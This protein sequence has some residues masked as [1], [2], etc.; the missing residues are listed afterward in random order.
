MKTELSEFEEKLLAEMQVGLVKAF[1]ERISS[2]YDSN[3]LAKALTSA[4]AKFAPRIQEQVENAISAA[5]ESK[6]F[7]AAINK[8]LQEKLLAAALQHIL[9][10]SEK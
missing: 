4:M 10:P 6:D 1:S 3:P 8:A 5:L 7:Q 2:G 9:K